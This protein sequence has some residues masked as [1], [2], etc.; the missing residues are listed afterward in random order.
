[1]KLFQFIFYLLQLGVNTQAMKI[2]HHQSGAGLG[3]KTVAE[4]KAEAKAEALA[5]GGA[6]AGQE[7]KVKKKFKKQSYHDYKD[8]VPA[9]WEV[10]YV[11]Y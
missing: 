3:A 4:A 5:E 11:K 2:R 6:E 9:L 7:V 10:L 1:M 8:L